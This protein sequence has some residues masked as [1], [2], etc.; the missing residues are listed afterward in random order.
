MLRGIMGLM[1]FDKGG[2]NI[3]SLHC[4]VPENVG[5]LL[6]VV[7]CASEAVVL[8]LWRHSLWTVLVVT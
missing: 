3:N 1:P 8:L 5:T 6:T 4:R 7:S 2:V